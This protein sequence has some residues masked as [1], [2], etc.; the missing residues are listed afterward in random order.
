[1]VVLVST[2]RLGINT[3]GNAEPDVKAALAEAFDGF[4]ETRLEDS[5]VLLLTDAMRVLPYMSEAPLAEQFEEDL[6]EVVSGEVIEAGA[7][8][9]LP[10]GQVVP[11]PRPSVVRRLVSRVSKMYLELRDRVNLVEHYD[12]ETF[13]KARVVGTYGGIMGFLA[14]VMGALARLLGL[15]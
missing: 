14:M 5:A 3:V 13:K 8:P 10:S 9:P 1:L 6:T 15:F 7:E 4:G 11:V 12:S 2:L